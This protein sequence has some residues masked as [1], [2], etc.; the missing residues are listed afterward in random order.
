LGCPK[1]IRNLFL[2]ENISCEN[3]KF[4]AENPL[5]WENSGPDSKVGAICGIFTLHVS[6][7]FLTEEAGAWNVN[8]I[9]RLDDR[10][11][12]EQT[13]SRPNGTLLPDSNIGLGLS[14]S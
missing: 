4:G 6:P 13:S 9:P 3:A 11:N 1:I 7:T 8:L 12:I 10:A 2:V 5:L 14:H